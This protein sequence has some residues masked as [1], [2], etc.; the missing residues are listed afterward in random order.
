MAWDSIVA[1][2]FLTAFVTVGIAAGLLKLYLKTFVETTVQES[3]KHQFEVERQK[4][5]EDFEREMQAGERKDKFRLAALDRRLDAHQRAFTLARRMI[6]T[7]RSS[8][9]TETNKLSSECKLFWEEQSL[10]L[11]NEVRKQF[12]KCFLFYNFYG[13]E[14][15]TIKSLKQTDS[16]YYKKANESLRAEREQLN[17]LPSLIENAVDLEAMGNEKMPN[18][19][20]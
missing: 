1:T 6:F 14:I 11:S 12:W 2:V 7:L 8:D 3:V 17:N 18:E 5:R 15:E 4:M 13:Q 10:F 19:E 20:E 9:P 16:E